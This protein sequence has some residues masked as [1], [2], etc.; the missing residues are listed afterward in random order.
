MAT[1]CPCNTSVQELSE[2]FSELR[3]ALQ[4]NGK[5]DKILKKLEKKI[6]DFKGD[7]I[8]R[9]QATQNSQISDVIQKLDQSLQNSQNLGVIL[10]QTLQQ[11]SSHQTSVIEQTLQQLSSHQTSV[12]ERFLT[13]QTSAICQLQESVTGQS[14]QMNSL[15]GKVTELESQMYPLRKKPH[16]DVQSLSF[17]SSRSS[18]ESINQLD[19][20]ERAMDTTVL[21]DLPAQDLEAP[22]GSSPHLQNASTESIPQQPAQPDALQRAMD[23][24][25]FNYLPADDELE[26]ATRS[27][28]YLQNAAQSTQQAT[29][30]PIPQQLAATNI[31][32]IPQQLAA[33]NI[34]SIPQPVEQQSNADDMPTFTPQQW[35]YITRM[36]QQSNARIMRQQS[37]TRI[38][39]QQS[40]SQITQQNISPRAQA[41]Q[42]AHLQNNHRENSFVANCPPFNEI[43]PTYFNE[44]YSGLEGLRR[45]QQNG[46][47]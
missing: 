37:N 22:T 26:A 16:I 10:Q 29:A 31:R 47:S 11:L 39:Q 36:Q 20:S 4:N 34:Q 13:H 44:A 25:V 1:S 6:D 15:T 18:S 5:G 23:T 40:N 28:S 35:D 2:G 17:S 3:I 38:M 24:T 21:N 19:A 45:A 9:N 33:T 43:P 46:N 30:E 42:I 14:I 7:C 12:I 32:S 27:L 41:D 8:L